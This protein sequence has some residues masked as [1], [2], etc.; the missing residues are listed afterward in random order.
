MSESRKKLARSK[1]LEH[2]YEPLFIG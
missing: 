1:K 2:Y